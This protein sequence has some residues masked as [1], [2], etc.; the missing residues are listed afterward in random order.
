MQLYGTMDMTTERGGGRGRQ[1]D[2][3]ERLAIFL[4]RVGGGVGVRQVATQFEVSEG[5]VYEVTMLVAQRVI[6]RLLPRYVKWPEPDEQHYIST[7]WELE[8]RLR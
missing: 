4:Y 8:K 2:P 3:A 1:F 5:S 6:D 7:C